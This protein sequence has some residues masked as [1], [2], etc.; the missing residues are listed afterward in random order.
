[1]EACSK[2]YNGRAD[3]KESPEAKF[4]SV[5]P[6]RTWRPSA[7]STPILDTDAEEEK[8]ILNLNRR[9]GYGKVVMKNPEK[10][11]FGSSSYEA[12]HNA[13]KVGSVVTSITITP[14]DPVQDT[15]LNEKTACFI[16]KCHRSLKEKDSNLCFGKER[17]VLTVDELGK[18]SVERG[19]G[20]VSCRVYDK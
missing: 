8:H 11:Y 13:L 1:M 7:N 18:S 17:F 9:I 5:Y 2:L 14:L 6:E 4:L 20:C 3:A 15:E 12:A 10:V 16:P 19:E